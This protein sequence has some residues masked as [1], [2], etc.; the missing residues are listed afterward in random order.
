MSPSQMWAST[1]VSPATWTAKRRSGRRGAMR[2]RGIWNSR[3][4]ARPSA[5]LPRP[6]DW[7]G[8]CAP[9]VRAHKQGTCQR[10]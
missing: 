9:A 1:M 4:P 10:C 3:L 5:S 2:E 6:V 8:P 7:R